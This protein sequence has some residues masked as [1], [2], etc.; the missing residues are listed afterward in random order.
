MLKFLL[1]LFVIKLYARINIYKLLNRYPNFVDT[2][3][4]DSWRYIGSFYKQI[5]FARRKK[6]SSVV[7]IPEIEK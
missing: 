7:D 5:D 6:S 1:I 4:T 3:D 2:I